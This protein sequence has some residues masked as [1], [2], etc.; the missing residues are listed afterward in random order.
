M[1]STLSSAILSQK[2]KK[3]GHTAKKFSTL[4]GIYHFCYCK[5]SPEVHILTFLSDGNLKNQTITMRNRNP[6]AMK[7]GTNRPSFLSSS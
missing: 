5:P 1:P 4:C 3:S 7:T 6:H 2:T